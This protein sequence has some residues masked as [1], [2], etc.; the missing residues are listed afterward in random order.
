[1]CLSEVASSLIT[2]WQV[3]VEDFVSDSKMPLHHLTG[4][5]KAPAITSKYSRKR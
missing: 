2:L 5:I 3:G 1:M 4:S